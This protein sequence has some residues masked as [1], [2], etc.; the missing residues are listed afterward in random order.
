MFQQTLQHIPTW[1]LGLLIGLIAL[2]V[3]QSLPRRLSLRRSAVLPLVLVGVSLIGVVN[4]FAQQPAA[5]L[6]WAIGLAGAVAALHG[7]VYPSAVRYSAR[8]QRFEVPGSWVPLALMM[9]LFAIKFG[10]GTGLALHPELRQSA[11]FALPISAAYG[12]FSGVFLG[13]AMAL[14]TLARRS[15]AHAA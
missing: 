5:L 3:S 10:A 8:S 13:R 12:L 4:T 6:A 14:W 15:W 9:G 2:G 1:V 7:G 11:L